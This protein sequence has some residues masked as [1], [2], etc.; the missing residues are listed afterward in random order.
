MPISCKLL[1]QTCQKHT[2]VFIVG[3]PKIVL[4][5]HNIGK[6][7]TTKEDHVLTSGRIFNLQF[8]FLQTFLVTLQYILQIQ[9]ANF[10]FQSTRQ[11]RVHGRTTGQDNM[12]VEFG[13]CINI[14]VLNCFINEFMDTKTILI[15]T[16]R[17]KQAFGCFETFGT[18]FD[19][20][21]IGKLK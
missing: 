12:F 9:V 5:L 2:L 21:T 20:T 1:V 18:N 16:S 4:V 19:F 15:D 3:H 7:S 14:G 17:G 10:L 8:E 11:A 13:S 6:H